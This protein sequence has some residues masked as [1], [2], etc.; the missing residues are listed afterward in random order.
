[1]MMWLS[2]VSFSNL[3]D[4]IKWLFYNHC[5]TD[6]QIENLYTYCE[7]IVFLCVLGF[8][9]QVAFSSSSVLK[10]FASNNKLVAGR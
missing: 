9:D 6:T 4:D 2:M 10:N 7:V 5:H 8:C 3:L 1:M